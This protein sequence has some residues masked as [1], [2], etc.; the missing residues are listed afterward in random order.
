MARTIADLSPELLR[1]MYGDNFFLEQAGEDGPMTDQDMYDQFPMWGNENERRFDKYPAPEQLSIP[2][3]S[4]MRTPGW[5]QPQQAP[6]MAPQAPQMPEMQNYFQRTTPGNVGPKVSMD[7]AA[8]PQRGG[9]PQLDYSSPIEVGGFGKGYR[10]KGD[11]SRIVLADGR[12]VRTGVDSAGE[13]KAR[14]DQEEMAI[15]RMVAEA[16]IRKLDR[17]GVGAGGGKPTERLSPDQR[18]VKKGDQWV[19]EV[20]PGSKLDLKQ[21]GDFATDQSS[22]GAIAQTTDVLERKVN[23]LLSDKA[24]FASNFGGYNALLTQHLP[25]AL[26]ASKTIESIKADLKGLGLEMMRT[27]GSIGAMTEKEWPIVEAR[28]AA[29]SPTLSEDKARDEFKNI[30]GYMQGIKKRAGEKLQTEWGDR[31]PQTPS[32]GSYDAEKEK[33]Y[34]AWKASQGAK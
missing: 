27:G 6:Q 22:Y 1:Q 2:S 34:Q 33:R 28:I 11:P 26:N 16:Q 14:K 5:N 18:W 30:L 19:A 20:I 17:D 8:Q 29:I 10:M 23:D 3:D 21:K 31:M 9:G 12:I 15:K 4:T 25:D 7:Y 24:G 13:A 32:G